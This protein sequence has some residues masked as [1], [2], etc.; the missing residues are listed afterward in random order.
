MKKEDLVH[1]YEQMQLIRKAEE[2]I[3]ELYPEQEMRCPVHLCIGQEAIAAGVCAHLGK[4]DYVLG[5][6]RAHGHYLAKGGDL[7]AF[8]AELL[9]KKTGC[10]GGMGGSMHLV[11]LEAGFLGCTPVVSSTIPIATGTAYSSQE[12]QQSRV[13]VVFFGDAAVEEGVFHESVNFALL[14]QL[15]IVFVCENNLYSVNSPLS[16]RQPK[17]QQI[18]ELAKGHGMKSFQGDGNDVLA[19]S[20]LAED[21]I[22]RA[23]K[24]SGPTFLEFATYRWREHCGPE[25]DQQL[26][27]RSDGELTK[28]KARCPIQ[29]FRN[30]LLKGQ[31]ATEQQ[32]Q[33]VETKIDQCLDEAVAFAKNSPF[34][35]REELTK[36]LYA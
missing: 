7:N 3:I 8:F 6:H 27:Y 35:E 2:R 26:G 36:Y 28:W 21:A 12:Q 10:S 34:P 9:G 19:V 5:T 11:D 15:P 4:E 31:K 23:R 17:N 25:Y 16:V 20:K 32:L 30:K 14:K 18:F 33:T 13:T 22:G 24:G 29:H 1:L